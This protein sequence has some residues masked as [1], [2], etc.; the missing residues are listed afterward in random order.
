MS[1]KSIEAVAEISGSKWFQLYIYKDR[2]VTK[3]LVD[4]VISSGYQA[5]CLTVDT[6]IEGRRE[7][8]KWNRFRL[9]AGVELA[10]FKDNPNLKDIGRAEN[11]SALTTYIEKLWDPELSWADVDWLAKISSIP[12]IV[13]GILSERDALISLQHGAAAII[14]SNHGGRQLD[15]A[16]TTARVLSNICETVHGRC[17]VYVDGGIRRGTHVLKALALGARAV[18]I[19]RP[20]MWGLALDGATG[21]RDV[22]LHLQEE[23]IA[24]MQLTGCKSLADISSEIIWPH[25]WPRFENEMSAGPLYPFQPQ[26]D[27]R[28]EERH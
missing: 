11:E 3:S 13:K 14:V 20:I 9:P 21:V 8:D 23:V 25:F 26:K 7:R 2:G 19:G 22:L 5:L 4:R 15:T 12:I 6:P 17:E 27:F 28:T 24:A 18:L 16:A 1:T 10:N